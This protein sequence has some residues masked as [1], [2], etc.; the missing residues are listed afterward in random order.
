MKKGDWAI[1]DRGEN[2]E[3]AVRI[4]AVIRPGLYKVES[5]EVDPLGNW[6]IVVEECPE[7]RLEKIE[8]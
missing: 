2:W 4:V 8:R 5:A 3:S 7:S 6:R 1:Q